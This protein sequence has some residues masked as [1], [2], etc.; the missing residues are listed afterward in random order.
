MVTGGNL[1][2][3]LLMAFGAPDSPEAV[4]PFLR[5]LLGNRPL[6]EPVLA[7]IKERYNLI[8]GKSPLLEITQTQAF[9]LEEKLKQ[10]GKS[11]RVYTGMCYWHPFIEEALAQMVEDGINRVLAL[12]LS[13][14]YSRVS[15]G[16]YLRQLEAALDRYGG[17][18]QVT[19]A[20]DWY[21]HPLYIQALAEKVGEGLRQFP[22]DVRAEVPLVFSAHSVPLE[23][24]EG[25]DPYLEQVEKTASALAETLGEVQWQ[26]AFQSKGAGKGRW[27]E[28][29]V[30]KVLEQLRDQGKK[31]VLLV[32]LSFVSDH[33]ETLYD[34]DIALKEYARSL[35]LNFVRCSTLNDSP[36][37][38]EALVQIIEQKLDQEWK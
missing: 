37:F 25:G 28:P 33:V 12:S 10:R 24:I 36:A 9:K 2:G 16:A 20:G 38:I 15:T 3:I 11:C 4:E 8:G 13:P 21:D 1:T 27:L 30:E 23:H 17:S 7:K 18:L 29:E 5:K 31:N 22:E 35:G 32:P 26:L 34:M 14:H 19:R 6:P